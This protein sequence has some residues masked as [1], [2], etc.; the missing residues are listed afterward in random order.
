[1]NA[2]VG[3]L[4]RR[5]HEFYELRYHEGLSERELARRLHLCRASVRWLDRCCR[6]TLLGGASRQ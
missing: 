4:P 2:R 3:E 6:Q 5:L 1:L